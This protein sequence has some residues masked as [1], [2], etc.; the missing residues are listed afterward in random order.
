MPKAYMEDIITPDQPDYD[1]YRSIYMHEGNPA[2]IFRPR[3]PEDVATA[4]KY[5]R[6]HKSILSIRSGGHSGPGFGTNTDGMVIDL[7]K[8]KHIEVIDEA[9]HIV[10]IGAGANWG[11]IAT[12][13]QK[14]KL[15]I[16]SGDTRSVGVGG[17]T[18]GGG[19]GWMV[20]K[21]GLA[22]DQLVGAEVVTADGEILQVSETENKDLFW[23]IRGGGGN[24][25]VVTYFEF[26]AHPLGQVYWSN[27]VYPAEMLE[28]VL[29]GW[30]DYMRTAPLDI[31]STMLVTPPSPQGPASIVLMNFLATDDKKTAED[32]IAPM[33]AWGKPMSDTLELKD[34]Y[35]VLGD[36][37]PPEGVKIIVRN[38]LTPDLS[39]EFLNLM[40]DAYGKEGSP[41]LM[42]RSMKGVLNDI[43]P[44]ATAFSFRDSEALVLSVAF[45]PP[46]MAAEIEKKALDLWASMQKYLSGPY[47]NFIGDV[48]D[49]EITTAYDVANFKKLSKLKKQYDPEN[50][51]NQNYNIK[52]A[53]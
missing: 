26:A 4:I 19:I 1:K 43:K 48:A 40:I 20:R 12:E 33:R 39:D 32:L 3:T 6:K 2:V 28:T 49:A 5:A 23:A 50:I 15:G 53:A 18:T 52:P 37:H 29:T 31:T 24:F 38:A 30:R 9:K 17:L 27:I 51:F 35:D 34:Y 22:L 46:A 14:H 8:M 10:R 44:T 7:T 13:L 41:M 42:L 11:E 25:G 36:A 16:S 21:Y 45:A 47:I